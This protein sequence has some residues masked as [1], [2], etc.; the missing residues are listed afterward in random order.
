[1]KSNMVH[2]PWGL[3]NPKSPCMKEGILKDISGL[4]VSDTVMSEDGYP[5]NKRQSPEAG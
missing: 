2:N 5:T 4:F 3:L 1:M